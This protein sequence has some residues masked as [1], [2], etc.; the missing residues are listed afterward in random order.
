[1]LVFLYLKLIY[2]LGDTALATSLGVSLG[3]LTVIGIGFT[4]FI[5]KKRKNI[6]NSLL[7]IRRMSHNNSDDGQVNPSSSS[8]LLECNVNTTEENVVFSIRHRNS[9]T[10]TNDM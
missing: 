1:M 4:L 3:V 8:N 9:F 7:Q 10:E 6:H 5:L 2:V